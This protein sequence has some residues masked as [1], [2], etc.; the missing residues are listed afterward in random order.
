[1]KRRELIRYAGVSLLTVMAS[2]KSQ[3]QPAG[4]T[5]EYLG[6]TSFLFT[7]DGVG[8]LVNPYQSLGC[9]AGYSLPNI[10]PDLVLISSQ[11]LDE[12]AY[13]K[14][15]GNPQ[16]LTEPGAYNIK[17]ISFQG[18]TTP[19]DRDGGKRFGNNIVWRWTQGGVK[20]L[21][22]GGA[23]APIE[24]EQKILMGSPDVALIPTGGGPK[25]YNPQ[26]ALQA[27]QSL[28]PR[29]I[30][31]TQYLTAAADKSACELVGVDEFLQLAE[32]MSI[33]VLDTNKITIRPVDLPEEG[34]VIRVLSYVA[35]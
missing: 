2:K 26:E 29:V 3:A 34:T 8:I 32:G 7:G 9:T 35:S 19:H 4:V 31:P 10:T 25:A 18:I 21:H 22:L 24:L 1:M 6:H 12:G 13:S 28:K 5:I 23:A 17:G 14:V 30:I 33:K 20:I 15:P 27:M 16:V 11:L